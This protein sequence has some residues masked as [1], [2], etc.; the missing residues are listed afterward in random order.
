MTPDTDDIL[1]NNIEEVKEQ[2]SKTYYL[3][4]EKNTI[5]NF[6]DGIEAMK[7]TIYC[8]LNTE[9]FEHLI[10]SWN[11]GIELKHLIGENTTFVIPELERVITEALMQDTRISEVNNFEFEVK[12]NTILAKFTVVT[13]VGEIEVEK[14]VS[15]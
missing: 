8:I 9:R 7:Q 2:T 3:N 5:S 1:L 4:I 15:I 6:C 10:Y 14:V 13:T 11:Y 12:E